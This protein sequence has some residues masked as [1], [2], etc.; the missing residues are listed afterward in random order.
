M[1]TTPLMMSL[2]LLSLGACASTQGP[3]PEVAAAQSAVHRARSGTSAELAPVQ[4]HLAEKTL[5]RAEMLAADDRASHRARDLAYIATRQAE[6]A[7]V[8]ASGEQAKLQAEEAKAQTLSAQ[9][10]IQEAASQELLTARAELERTE[11][12]LQHVFTK[13]NELGSKVSQDERGHVITLSGNVLFATGKSTLLSAAKTQLDQIAKALASAQAPN[14][15]IEGYADGT[16]PAELNNDLSQRRADA[17]RAYLA[18]QGLSKAKI[19]AVG[20]GSTRPLASNRTAEGRASNRRVEIVVQ[21][22]QS[23]A[24]R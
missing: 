6:I 20:R 8:T 3:P 14:M 11:Q 22:Q 21:D 7:E 9:T 24:S 17:V 2:S 23:A 4:L 13:L 12:E 18:S 19:N 15:V 1:K 10:S 16:G 5:E